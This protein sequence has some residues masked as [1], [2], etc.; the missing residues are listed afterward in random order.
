MGF[1]FLPGD[2]SEGQKVTSRNC[3]QFTAYFDGHSFTLHPFAKAVGDTHPAEAG[4]AIGETVQE[5]NK[6]IVRRTITNAFKLHPNRQVGERER[7]R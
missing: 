5:L 3:F 1:S 2:E 4:P 7:K 6:G